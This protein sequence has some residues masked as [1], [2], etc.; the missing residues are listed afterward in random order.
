MSTDD[1]AAPLSQVALLAGLKPSQ[2]ADM[3]QRAEKLRYGPGET[4]IKAGEPGDG[5]YLL[6]SGRVDCLTGSP[7]APAPEPVE[8]GSL[9]GE[10][11]MLIEYNYDA[12]F[13]ARERAFCLKLSRAAMHAQMLEDRSLIEHFQRRITERLARVSEDLRRVD[14]ALTA[15]ASASVQPT[16]APEPQKFVAAARAWR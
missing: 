16:T 11:A 10:M 15:G 13:V 7:A 14:D 2:L 5:A 6:V 9:M 8:P 3:A 12:T 1:L 4:V